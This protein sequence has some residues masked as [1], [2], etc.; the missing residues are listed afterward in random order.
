MSVFRIFIFASLLLVAVLP[1]LIKSQAVTDKSCREHPQLVGSCFTVYGRLSVYNGAPALRIWKVGTK[2]VLGISDQR[3]LK[4]G[5]RNIPVN[6]REL[7]NQDTDVYGNFQVCP[8]TKSLPNKMQL[9]CVESGKNLVKRK[10]VTG[11]NN[12][13]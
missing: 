2:R 3:F 6:I 5:Y 12:S 9:V 11:A 4:T 13:R 7:V 8:F 10:S 1:T